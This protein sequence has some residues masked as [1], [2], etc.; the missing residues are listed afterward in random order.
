MFIT[1]ILT[2]S[3][4]KASNC[5]KYVN[6]AKTAKGKNLIQAYE[7]LVAC[8]KETAGLE[9]ESFMKTFSKYFKILN[10]D[11]LQKKVR[12]CR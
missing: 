9:F 8:D 1:L 5:Q 10:F 12:W 11:F 2:L 6:L 4:A 7:K 3:T